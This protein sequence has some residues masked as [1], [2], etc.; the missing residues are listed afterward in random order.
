M[1]NW[2][3]NG[4]I[5]A[6]FG[7]NPNGPGSVL[8]QPVDSRPRDH[9]DSGYLLNRICILSGITC[10]SPG[11]TRPVTR[12]GWWVSA[13][14]HRRSSYPVL[15]WFGLISF[16]I[17][18]YIPYIT[19]YWKFF[20]HY[21]FDTLQYNFFYMSLW[22]YPRTFNQLTSTGHPRQPSINLRAWNIDHRRSFP[23]LCWFVLKYTS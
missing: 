18:E 1:F 16:L 11:C 20:I 2:T 5:N 10:L 12:A 21:I 7:L 4:S 17:C 15:C 19:S 6:S 3:G 14:H 23:V 9:I 8:S 13:I 22:S